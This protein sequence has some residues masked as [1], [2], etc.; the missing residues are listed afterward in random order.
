[1]GPTLLVFSPIPFTNS[2]AKPHPG[3]AEYLPNIV[4]IGDDMPRHCPAFN[5]GHVFKI[6]IS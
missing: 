6:P 4:V 2:A 5:G 3:Q 1:M